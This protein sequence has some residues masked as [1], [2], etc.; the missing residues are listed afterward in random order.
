MRKILFHLNSMEK[1]GAE[2]VVN[3]LSGQ[4]YKNGYEVVLATEWTGKD[5]YALCDGVRRVHV[6]LDNERGGRIH[7]F[8]E[9]IYKLR[10]TIKE[11]QPDV[12]I[13][14]AKK[15][16][17]RALFA[18]VGTKVPVILSVRTSPE[19]NYD[20]LLDRILIPFL[21]RRAAGAVFQTEAAR[22]FFQRK[23]GERSVVILN[24]L[25]DCY[26]DRIP[27]AGRK[28][29]IVQVGRLDQFKD[30]I[31]LLDAM[32]RVHKQY[33]DY[34]LRIYGG[35][36]GDGTK[37]KLEA[38]IAAHDAGEYIYLM[39]SVEHPEEYIEDAAVFVLSSWLEGMPNALMEAMA[40]GLPVVATDCSG[41]GPATLITHGKNGLLVPVKDAA[42]MAEAVSHLIQH[43]DLAEQMGQQAKKIGEQARES[44]VFAAWRDYI[45]E[46][47]GRA[48]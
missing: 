32:Y 33:P 38:S 35:D 10:K 16:I 13:A 3:I 8:S 48:N 5:E 21:Y 26:L 19:G 29:E 43:A 15:A 46:Q 28:K 4:F 41:G 1:G 7:N 24:P 42:A 22:D 18:T 6:G 14:F 9:R 39:G 25:K 27:S 36:S 40:L 47:I 2:R 34:I 31:V 45:E 11:E 44:V 23:L 30:Q 37:Q 17:Y 12:V 20:H